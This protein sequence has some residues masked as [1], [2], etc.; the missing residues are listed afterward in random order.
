MLTSDFF[1]VQKI[2]LWILLQHSINSFKFGA[3]LTLT[4]VQII[5]PTNKYLEQKRVSDAS[6]DAVLHGI[7]LSVQY[8]SDYF[9]TTGISAIS[10]STTATHS[11]ADEV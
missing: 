10:L 5:H 1:E 3:I 11:P 9:L 4:Q 2:S 6:F 7:S 8:A